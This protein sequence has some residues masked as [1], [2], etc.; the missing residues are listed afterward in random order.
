MNKEFFKNKLIKKHGKPDCENSLNSYLGLV[1][2]DYIFKDTVYTEKHHVLTRSQ[3]SNLEKEDWNIIKLK[4]ED[5][6]QAHIL[7]FKAFNIRAYQ[8]PLLF[9]VGNFKDSES[10]SKAAK[11]GWV[12]LK[13]DNKKYLKWK[14]AHSDY[15]STLSS[16]E[17]SRRSKLFWDSIT[18]IE[19]LLFSEKIKDYWTDKKREE[20]SDQMKQ[21]FEDNPGEASRRTNLRYSNWSEKEFNSFK[22][23]MTEVNKSK[24]KRE[25]AGKTIKENWAK[26][27]FRKKMLNRKIRV[28]K[29]KAISP[30]GE[31]FI[32]DGFIKMINEFN[33][34]STLVRKFKNT[35]KPVEVK[36]KLNQKTI[37]TIGWLFYELKK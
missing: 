13:K 26:P 5:H 28:S 9:M 20:K 10:I 37:N 22:E 18:A 11:R 1:T 15:M 3:F 33:F 4:Y 36:N 2:K 27:E 24:E 25:K 19:K 30:K 17:Q 31:E 21:Y 32:I 23:K 14:K 12:K 35:N 29:Y 8:Y 34:N 6:I 16:E 7:L